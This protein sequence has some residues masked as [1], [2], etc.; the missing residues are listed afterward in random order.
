MSR[1]I[2]VRLIAVGVSAI[3]F[4]GSPTR[5]GDPRSSCRV[6]NTVT[7]LRATARGKRI[8]TSATSWR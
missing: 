5:Y 1:T 3:A 7:G 8:V 4:A 6:T 2:I